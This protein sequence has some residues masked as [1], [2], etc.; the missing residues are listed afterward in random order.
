MTGLPATKAPGPRR[1]R[2]DRDEF[3]LKI[4]PVAKRIGDATVRML[5]YNGSIPGPTLKLS[6]GASVT[7]QVTNRGDLDATVFQDAAG[8][9]VRDRE[10]LER[11]RALAIPPAWEDVWICPSPTGHV[12]AIINPIAI[13]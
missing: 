5:A 1:A 8:R 6:Q 7:V 4:S 2:F 10:T 3:D 11:I 12:Q 13:K 9:L